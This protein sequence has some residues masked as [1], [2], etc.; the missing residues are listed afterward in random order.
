MREISF[1]E[2]RIMKI[3][4]QPSGVALSDEETKTFTALLVK[5]GY[6]VK[7]R[8]EKAEGKSILNRIIYAEEENER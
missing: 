8:K 4:K 3:Y 2:G 5:L 1:T 6:T 7:I